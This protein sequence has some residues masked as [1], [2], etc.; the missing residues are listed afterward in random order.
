M[1]MF[2]NVGHYLLVNYKHLIIF[3]DKL[4][5]TSDANIVKSVPCVARV[6]IATGSV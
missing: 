3:K 2:M 4:K 5:L 6:R 1:M